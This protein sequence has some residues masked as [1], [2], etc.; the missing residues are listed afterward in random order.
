LVQLFP[1]RNSNY[2]EAAHIDQIMGSAPDRAKA[3]Q[4]FLYWLKYCAKPAEKAAWD[5]KD[6]SVKDKQALLSKWLVYKAR[7]FST[8]LSATTK[9]EFVVS[10]AAAEQ[11][12]WWSAERMDSE[13]GPKKAQG[14]RDSNRLQTRPCRVTG[15]TEEHMLE[16]LITQD[17]N[18]RL[19]TN[20]TSHA[21]TCSS[22]S[23]D[24]LAVLK[25]PL[26]KNT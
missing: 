19:E 1:F 9:Q 7:N 3:S 4:Q 5:N 17:T 26:G 23:G 21:T 24:A 11:D 12:M 18:T 2:Q 14:M 8:E 22:T 20:A 25:D 10:T 15:S 16:Y 6:L 13:L